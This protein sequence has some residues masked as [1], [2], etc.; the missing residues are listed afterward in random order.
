MCSLHVIKNYCF[1]ATKHVECI[2]AQEKK[3]CA[4]NINVKQLPL[5]G[6]PWWVIQADK[7][8]DTT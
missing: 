2:Q 1:T 8:G 3:P 7:G 4:A 5:G 6:D